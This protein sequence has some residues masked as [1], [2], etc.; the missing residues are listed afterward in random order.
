MKRG[1]RDLDIM[2]ILKSNYVQNLRKHMVKHS[3]RQH[4]VPEVLT[5]IFIVNHF[6]NFSCSCIENKNRKLHIWE[7]A[8]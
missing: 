2:V 7:F 3:M 5:N 1:H 4:I 8:K 6:K